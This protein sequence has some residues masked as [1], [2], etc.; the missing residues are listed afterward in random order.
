MAEYL[1]QDIIACGAKEGAAQSDVDIV[2]T[3]QY[4]STPY[5]KCVYACTI[6]AGGMVKYKIQKLLNA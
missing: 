5:S 1:K 4:P 2:L 3:S 6:E